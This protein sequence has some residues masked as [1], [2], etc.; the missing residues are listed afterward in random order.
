MEILDFF[1]I[2]IFISKG[3]LAGLG[4]IAANRQSTRPQL[5]PVFNIL[6]GSHTGSPGVPAKTT[7]AVETLT[8]LDV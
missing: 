8:V 3:W 5:G 1:L 7:P 6:L 2:N 4:S